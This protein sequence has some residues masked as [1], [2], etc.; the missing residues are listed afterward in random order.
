MKLKQIPE[1]FRVEE[2]IK[3]P[4]PDAAGQH[5]YFWLNK[6]NYTTVR[7]ILAIAKALNVS[8]ARFHFAGTKDANAVTKQLVSAFQI[9]PE[10]LSNLRLKDIG[11]EI[12]GKPKPN[13]VRL[14]PENALHFLGFTE[15]LALGD[16]TGNRFEIVLRDLSR[17]EIN[18]IKEQYLILNKDGFPNYFGEQRFGG[19]NSALIGREIVRGYFKDAVYYLLTYSEKDASEA[20]FAAPRRASLGSG[21]GEASKFRALAKKKFS[22]WD[23]LLQ[24]CPK[25]LGI[26]TTVL[27]HLVQVPTDF[28]GALRKIPKPTRRMYVHAYQ[29]YLWNAGLEKVA[30]SKT[31]KLNKIQLGRAKLKVPLRKLKKSYAV[32]GFKTKLGKDKFS[33][34]I[35][36]LLF[37]DNLTLDSFRCSRMPELASEG[38]ARAAIIKPKKLKLGKLEK[39]ELNAG[40]FKLKLN[41]ELPKGAYATELVK[42]L[43][44]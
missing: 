3:L 35:K 10:R 11:I 22:S 40:K 29:S 37:A 26:E 30:N 8:F 44:G 33:Q 43:S 9:P 12:V 27:K 7:A 20:S 25:F 6:R 31:P 28:A 2:L 32:P 17:N 42:V 15:R 14:G 41:F 36:K 13:K 21:N 23:T 24:A 19:G 18:N 1:D 16:L 5:T 39:D 4:K 38:T 34:E